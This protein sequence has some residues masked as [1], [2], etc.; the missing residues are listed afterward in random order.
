V[1]NRMR[2]KSLSLVLFFGLAYAI[3]WIFWLPP[4]WLNISIQTPLGRLFETV[5]NFGPFLAALILIFFQQGAAGIRT[6]RDRLFAWRVPAR[7][8]LVAL[9]GPFVLMAGAIAASTALGRPSIELRQPGSLLLL[10]PA[11]VRTLLVAGGL[12]EETG[13]RGYALPHLL[14]R[15][16]AFRSSVLLGVLWGIWHAPLYFLPGTGQNDMIRSGGSFLFLFTGFVAWT[17]ALSILFTWLHQMAQG[18]LLIVILFHAAI[19]TAAS[20]PFLLGIQTS[21]ASLLYP[22]FTWV[23]ALIVTRLRPFVGITRR[24]DRP[25]V[26]GQA[27]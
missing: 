3:S 13:W 21:P 11:F 14:A 18:S 19:N 16:G 12:N 15:S 6:L 24:V 23:A 20:L 25:S 17:I 10:I 27:E 1:K 22:A 4:V 8:Y 26:S 5:G 7:W 2:P 9:L